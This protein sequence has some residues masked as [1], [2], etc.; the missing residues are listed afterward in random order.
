[1]D[2]LPL[3]VELSGGQH[4]GPMTMPMAMAM[5]LIARAFDMESPFM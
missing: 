1:V 4:L 2:G 5:G 3:E